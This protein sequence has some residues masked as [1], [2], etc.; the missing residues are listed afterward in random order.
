[1]DLLDYFLIFIIVSLVVAFVLKKFKIGQQYFFL[2]T[3]VR[4]KWP[5]KYFDMLAHHK[6]I[7]NFLADLG[8]I[9][10][11]GAVGIDFLFGK[12]QPK[13][14]RAILF[15]L[16]AFVL[17]IFAFFILAPFLGSPIALHDYSILFAIAFGLFGL[18]GFTLIALVVSAYEIIVRTL[19]GIPSCPAVAPLIPGVELPNVPITVPLHGWLSLIIILVLHEG[20]HGIL[21]RKAK[22][23]VKSAGILLLGFLPIGAFVEPNDKSLAKAKPIEQARIFVA[24][25]AANFYTFLGTLGIA[26]LVLFLVINP[27]ILPKFTEFNRQGTEYVFISQVTETTDFCNVKYPNSAFGVLEPG[28]KILEANGKPV[29]IVQDYMEAVVNTKTVTMKLETQTGE[30]VEKTL[31]KNEFN[32]LGFTPEIKK[33]E[34]FALPPEWMAIG[35]IISFLGSFVYWFILLNIM[36]AT[37]NFLPTEPFDGG[38]IAK[39]L[40]PDYLKF[41][42]LNEEKRRKIVS[43]IFS[44]LILTLFLLNALPLFF[45]PQ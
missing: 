42:G 35:V 20:S 19:Q 8:L 33:K 32:L 5:V 31:T 24:G 9:I 34:G 36:V 43:K 37:V 25:A 15:A 13:H 2:V 40:L 11:F 16:S 28:W 14:K 22:I 45:V 12:H 3:M 17:G 21:A 6:K 39:I 44:Y 30:I 10:G 23:L 18:S 4:A 38:K 29:Q 41:T 26:F 7:L 1:M 27:F